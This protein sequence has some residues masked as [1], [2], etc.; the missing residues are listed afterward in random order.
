MFFEM[1]EYCADN[2][3]HLLHLPQKMH[4]ILHLLIPNLVQLKIKLSLCLI[5]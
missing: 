4:Y 3:N 2:N 5:N 1:V